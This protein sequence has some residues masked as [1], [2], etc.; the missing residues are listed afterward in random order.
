MDSDAAAGSLSNLEQGPK[1]FKTLAMPGWH[2]GTEVAAKDSAVEGMSCPGGIT[3]RGHHAIIQ[4][5]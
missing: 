3:Q 5:I 4:Q 1:L 2:L